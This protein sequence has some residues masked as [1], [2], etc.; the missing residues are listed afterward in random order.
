LAAYAV[1]SDD[2]EVRIAL[3]W[4]TAAALAEDYQVFVH[5]LDDDGDN[6]LQADSGPLQ[7]RYPTSQ[8][9]TATTIRDTH[10]LPASALPEI[11][12]I[13]IGL[14][15]LGDGRRLPIVGSASSAVAA[16]S[17]LIFSLSATS[18]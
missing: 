8:W 7:G 13:R 5:V 17:L 1:E 16:D 3:Y 18:Q 15:R 14:Y 12:E 6:V 4:R 11:G 2:E 10:V 9:R